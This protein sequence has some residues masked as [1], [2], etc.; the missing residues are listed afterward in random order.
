MNLFSI[1]LGYEIFANPRA[2]QF[3][4]SGTD[5]GSP[6]GSW[7]KSIVDLTRY[8][9]SGDR[10]RLRWDLST[11]YCFGANSGWYLDNVRVYACRS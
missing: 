8:A 2:G 4:F 7:G 6:K 1:D 3:A 11:D 5:A 10:I 9:R